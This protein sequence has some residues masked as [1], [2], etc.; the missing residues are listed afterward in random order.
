MLAR[1]PPS[2]LKNTSLVQLKLPTSGFFKFCQFV[3]NVLSQGEEEP[4]QKSGIQSETEN[5]IME[6]LM[7][8]LSRGF[9]L[10]VAK[11]SHKRNRL[12]AH[13]MTKLFIKKTEI[14]KHYIRCTNVGFSKIISI[15]YGTI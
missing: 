2:P 9:C 1:E 7:S 10:R 3:Q 8:I 11:D 5:K 4:R 12:S 13:K 15:Y 6:S 14:F